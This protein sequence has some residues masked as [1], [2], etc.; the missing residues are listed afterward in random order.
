[1]KNDTTAPRKTERIEGT[2]HK[3]G[4]DTRPAAREDANL[5]RERAEECEVVDRHKNSGQKDHKGA[6]SSCK[7]C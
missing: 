5:P 3:A 2:L 1:M 7:S 6:R 4:Y